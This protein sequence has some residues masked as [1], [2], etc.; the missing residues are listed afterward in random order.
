MHAERSESSIP[1]WTSDQLDSSIPPQIEPPYFDADLDAWIL[2]RHEDVLAAFRSSALNVDSRTPRTHEDEEAMLKMRVETSEALSHA[3]LRTWSQQIAPIVQQKVIA[4][5]AN[6]SFGLS[7]VDLLDDYIRPACLALAVIVTEI[8]PLHAV[9]LRELTQPVSASAAEPYDTELSER[10]KHV[11]PQLEAC[12]HAKAVSLRDSGFVALSHTL[13]C[14][15]ANGFYGLLKYPQQWALLH[16][17]PSLVE[18][19]VEEMMR[20]AGLVRIVRRCA[21]E[22]LVLGGVSIRKGDHL[23]LR[24]IAANRDP[25]RFEHANELDVRRRDG[26]Q[27][28]LGAGAHACVGASLIR[29]AS[30]LITRSLVEACAGAVLVESVEWQGGSGFRSPRHLHVTLRKIA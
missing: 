22:E 19:A 13:P 12:F 4:L 23:I 25:A 6:I 27:L 8:D 26:G 16:H 2:S 20:Y 14:L 18:H 29:M 28:M 7:S 17:Q 24:L 15:L 3:Q 1:D 5:L 11:T 9:E 10:S 30:V 21:T